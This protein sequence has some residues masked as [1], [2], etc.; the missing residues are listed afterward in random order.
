MSGVMDYQGNVALT[1]GFLI[2]HP[3]YALTYLQGRATSIGGTVVCRQKGV[4]QGILNIDYGLHESRTKDIELCPETWHVEQL[5]K[6]NKEVYLRLRKQG[7]DKAPEGYK[8]ARKELKNGL[9]RAR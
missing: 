6:R 3:W 5:V 4:T 7:M 8:I 2:Q 1:A 9:R